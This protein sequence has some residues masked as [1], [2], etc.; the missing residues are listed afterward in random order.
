MGWLEVLA[1]L[2]RLL[3]LLN[4]IAPMLESYVGGRIAGRD[5][6]AA[7]ERISTDLKQHLIATAA[8]SRS[9][10]ETELAQQTAILRELTEEVRRLKASG[11]E[12]ASQLA[13]LQQQLVATHT[14]V[15]LLAAGMLLI[16][17]VVIV[18]L[19]RR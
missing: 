3:P 10:T 14:M 9:E 12:R 7:L 2:K 16:L 6:T 18:M 4:R 1:M 19:F 15:R 13:G 8:A 11:D 5:D 17:V